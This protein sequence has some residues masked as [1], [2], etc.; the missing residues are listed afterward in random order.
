[1]TFVVDDVKEG[2]ITFVD[3]GLGG[4]GWGGVNDV[5]C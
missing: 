4:V 5:R 2:M 1:M 3:V